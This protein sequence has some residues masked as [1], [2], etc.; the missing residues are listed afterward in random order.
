MIHK[1]LPTLKLFLAGR[2]FPDYLK[3]NVPQNVIC[4]GE[5]INAENYMSDKQIMIVP[6]LSGGGMRVKILQGMAMGKTIISTSIGA[7][8][9]KTEDGKNILIASAPEQFLKQVVKCSEDRDWCLLIG[10]SARK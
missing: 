7:E 10:K 5:I 1:K 8:G 4:E 3:N 6:L 2:G 9:I